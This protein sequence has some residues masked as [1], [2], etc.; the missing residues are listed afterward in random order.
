[1]PVLVAVGLVVVLAAGVG[2]WLT[3]RPSTATPGGVPAAVVS[4]CH[5]NALTRLRSPA[6]AK[7]SGEHSYQTTDGHWHLLGVVD[8]QNGFGALVRNKFD[9]DALPQDGAWVPGVTFSDWP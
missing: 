1:M 9:C 3:V 6:S 4:A 7:F 5:D 2:I 8:S